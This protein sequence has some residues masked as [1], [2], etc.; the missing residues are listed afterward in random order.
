MK[1]KIS[2]VISCPCDTYSG[3]GRRALDFVKQLL[4]IR[5]DWDIRILSQRWGDTRMGFLQDS[6]EW[7]ILSRTIPQIT[8]KPDIWIQITVPN[9]FQPVGRFNVGVTAAIETNLCDVSWIEGCNRMD[10]VLASSEHGKHSLVDPEYTNNQ[11]GQK[12]RV[13][14]PVEVLFEG[15]D[16]DTYFKKTPAVKAEPLKD[17]KNAWNFLCVGHWLQG[18]FGEDR[19]NIGYTIKVFLETF[20]DQKQAPG[21]IL[22]T[23]SATTSWMDQE[24]II[25]KISDIVSSVQYQQ[26]LP[27]I[28]LLHGDLTDEEMNDVYNDPRV[29]AMVSFTKGE[30]YG[31]PLAEFA[32]TGKPIL[33]S[34]WSGHR[35]FLNEKM[36]AMVGGTL[37]KVHPSAVQPHMILAEASWFKP[38]DNQAV[39]GYR[40]VYGNYD[41]WNKQA[42]KQARTLRV[43]KSIGA[44]GDELDTILD[45]ALKDFPTEVELALPEALRKVENEAER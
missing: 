33:V 4:I 2:C 7:E 40:E 45:S 28:Y 21:L 29:K 18:A 38:N 32:L 27:N 10:L 11:T 25:N 31:R 35:D 15:I 36:T 1:A 43:T 5:P 16:T 17:L 20:K 9:E 12:L 37:E 26:S 39:A 14:T 22:K 3:Y 24:V 23:S 44:M 19:K 34:G 41:Y 13:T 30:G 8:E 42:E 6:G